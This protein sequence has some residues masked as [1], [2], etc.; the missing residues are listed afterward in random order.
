MGMMTQLLERLGFVRLRDYGL[1]LTP[2]RR[3]VP[4][5]VAPPPEPTPSSAYHRVRWADSELRIFRSL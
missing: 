3:V 2:D 1:T 5:D 4:M